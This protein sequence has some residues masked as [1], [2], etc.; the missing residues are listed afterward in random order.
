MKC[1][2]TGRLAAY[3]RPA[4]S[5]SYSIHISVSG[6]RGSARSCVADL[7][8]HASLAAIVQQ[9]SSPGYFRPLSGILFFHL[10]VP[11]TINSGHQAPGSGHRARGGEMSGQQR[12]GRGQCSDLDRTTREQF[13]Y[14]VIVIHLPSSGCG[15]GPWT[16]LHLPPRIFSP[17]P[18]YL[19]LGPCP[20]QQ[21][22]SAGQWTAA[23]ARRVRGRIFADT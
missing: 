20:C 1:C 18:R 11:T 13:L 5:Y 6:V 23:R 15:P 4:H 17:L 12:G 19:S 16:Q 22:G 7:Y 8:F 3:L 21:R 10:T 9:P 14:L 2:D